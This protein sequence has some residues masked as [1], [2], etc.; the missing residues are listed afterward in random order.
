MI[1]SC[2]GIIIITLAFNYWLIFP[3]I[4]LTAATYILRV[5]YLATSQSVKRMEGVSK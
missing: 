2:I 3:V 4:L 1:L 5:I